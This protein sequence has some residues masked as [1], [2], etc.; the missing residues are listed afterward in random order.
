MELTHLTQLRT[1][2]DA[3]INTV[4]AHQHGDR[5]KL[6]RWVVEALVNATRITNGNPQA[7]PNNAKD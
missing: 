2:A 5:D 3:L 6:R 7:A 1:E 4:I